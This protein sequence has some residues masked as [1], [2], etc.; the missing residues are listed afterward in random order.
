MRLAERS[1]PRSNHDDRCERRSG[2]G[3]G[4]RLRQHG[5]PGHPIDILDVSSR[6][7]KAERCEP[8][9]AGTYAWLTVPGMGTYNARIVWIDSF[10]LGCEF[11]TPLDEEVLAGI[12]LANRRDTIVE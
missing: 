4:A 10:R 6:G 8:F 3:L 7:F 12:I 5:A 9:R 11:V 1:E 2:V